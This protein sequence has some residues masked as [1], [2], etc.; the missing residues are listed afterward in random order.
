MIFRDV[1]AAAVVIVVAAEAVVIVVD[2]AAAVCT[3]SQLIK[4]LGRFYQQIMRKNITTFSRSNPVK[5]FP[6]EK[7][8]LG[9]QTINSQLAVVMAQLVERLLPIPEVHGSNPVIGK[10]LFILNICLLSTVY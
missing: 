7:L 3:D 8:H 6:T 1:V 10:N 5:I 2:A 4:R 9:G